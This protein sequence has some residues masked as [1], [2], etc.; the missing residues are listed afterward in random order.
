MRYSVN[1][2]IG[3]YFDAL[4]DVSNASGVCPSKEIRSLIEYEDNVLSESEGYIRVIEDDIVNAID[5]FNMY[6]HSRLLQSRSDGI[7]NII[8]NMADTLKNTKFVLNYDKFELGFRKFYGG[9]SPTNC[10]HCGN[11]IDDG[12]NEYSEHYLQEHTNDGI[13]ETRIGYT[14]LDCDTKHMKNFKECVD[15]FLSFNHGSRYV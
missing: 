8:V 1:Q 4:Y 13:K 3:I 14:C 7:G 2:H 12:S 15:Y 5:I 9:K 10:V 6:K 11:V